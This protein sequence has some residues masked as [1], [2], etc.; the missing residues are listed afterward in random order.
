MLKLIALVL[1][2][3]FSVEVQ[4]FTVAVDDPRIPPHE[5][6]T[7]EPVP[8]VK[9]APPFMAFFT[10]TYCGPCQ[11]VKKNLIPQ[12]EAAGYRVAVYEMTDSAN[13]A[14]YG[15]VIKRVPA[16][17]ACDGVT[18]KWLTEPRFGAIDLTTAKWMLDGSVL[19][20]AKQSVQREVVLT[21]ERVLSPRVAAPSRFIQWPGWG[22]IDL[23]TYNRNC[24]CGMCQSIRSQQ[25]EYRRQLQLFQ[26]PQSKVTPDQEGTPDALVQD[27]LDKMQLQAGDV[28]AELG[29]GDGRILIAAAKRGIRGI[30]VE[31]DPI[32]A[33]VARENVQRH[34]FSE[35]I[36]VE[37]GDA[38]EFDLSRATVATTYLYPPLLAKLSPKLK[39]LRVVGSPY[40]EVPGLPMTQFGDVWIY[41]NGE[42][43]ENVVANNI[44]GSLR[45][46]RSVA[47]SSPD[48]AR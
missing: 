16:F 43:D 21:E 25:Q 40:H 7:L 3:Q 27:L 10:A 26:Q 35:L 32:R 22:T 9:Q 29:C 20:P 42:T 5:P 1:A 41:R 4:P 47:G 45:G 18:G 23:E 31:L 38:L 12:L 44:V 14:T 11:G 48:P 33:Q 15:S 28:L 19:S 6:A 17:I 30:G 8:I 39:Q 13:Q 36:T 37:T 2:C 34:G 46:N 24:N